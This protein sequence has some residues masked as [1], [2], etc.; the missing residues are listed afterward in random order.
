M[1]NILVGSIVTATL[2]LVGCGGGSGSNSTNDSTLATDVSSPVNSLADSSS[3]NTEKIG[4]GYYVDNAVEGVNYKCGNQEGITDE[5]GTFHFENGQN[6]TFVLGD[7]TLREVNASSLEDNVSVLED[8]TTVAQLLQT[9]DRDGNASNGIQIP[10]GAGQV[11]R[12]ELTSL[13]KPLDRDL[14]EAIH[15]AIKADS[16]NEYHG[17]V[18]DI[19]ET[20]R[21]LGETRQRLEHDGR[22]TQHQVEAEHHGL[23]RFGDNNGTIPTQEDIEAHQRDILGENNGAIPTQEEREAHQRDVLGENHESTGFQQIGNQ[24]RN[25]SGSSRGGFRG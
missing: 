1:K 22:R 6:C 20:Q 5:N 8:N 11:I 16:Q 3:A 2:L 18:V 14:L 25:G 4:K 9:L 23:G 19:N 10:R 21:H 17:R 7:L 15:D 12:D 13:D 24:N